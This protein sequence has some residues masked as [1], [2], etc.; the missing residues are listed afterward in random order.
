MTSHD[1][2][3]TAPAPAP[4]PSEGNAQERAGAVQAPPGLAAQDHAV[5]DHARDDHT[6]DHRAGGDQ[7]GADHTWDHHAGHDHAAEDRAGRGGQ[8]HAA[9]GQ[10]G[11][12]HR[13]QDHAGHGHGA[14]DHGGHN[15]DGH[16]PA[17]HSHG[18]HGHSHAPAIDRRNERLVL[19]TLFITLLFMTVEV[20]GGVV[21]GSL[22]LIADAGHMMTDAA[23]LAL[24]WAAF[25]WGRRAPDAARSFGYARFEVLAAFVNALA[26]L[27]L[28]L[29]IGWEAVSRLLDP[30]PV[31]AGPMMVIAVIGLLVNIGVYR[32]LSRGDR[33]H[34]N[35]RGALVHVMGDL[36]GSVAAI[37]AAL[38]I[39]S[40]GWTPID[41][42]LSILLSLLV[43][44]AGWSLMKSS[45]HILMEGTP[46]GLDIP[47]LRQDLVAHVP[48][49]AGV[50][51]V[52][53]W[54]ITSGR[55]M[56]TMTVTLRDPAHPA[57]V[58][59][60]LKAR[61][62]DRYGIR[63]STVEIDW[64]GSADACAMN[65]A[66]DRALTGAAP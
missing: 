9:Y 34:V 48:G 31:L 29:W 46:R 66:M 30:A 61:L 4:H 57:P 59:A 18:D 41:P 1:T 15:H 40:T 3:G 44:R 17:G 62:G 47:A 12:D 53:A 39:W 54:S 6:G 8:D 23:A 20:I 10:A 5:E 36:L 7:A 22:A 45:L 26:L 19:V 33:E 50:D 32:L 25:R 49:L 21:S 35:I 51:H 64:D 38:V 37:A 43:L 55:V 65:R 14:D 13:G 58:I 56:A 63:H 28:V 60:A 2:P 11:H 24:A 42:I 16:D 27:L 52:H